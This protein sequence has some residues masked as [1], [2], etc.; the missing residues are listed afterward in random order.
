MYLFFKLKTFF[1][2]LQEKSYVT[3]MQNINDS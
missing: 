2:G 3:A 1:V